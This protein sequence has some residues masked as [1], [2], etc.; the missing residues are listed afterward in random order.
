MLHRAEP[1]ETDRRTAEE[2]LRETPS[3]LVSAVVHLVGLLVLALW[4]V[5][6]LPREQRLDLSTAFRETVELEELETLVEEM[7]E[8]IELTPMPEFASTEPVVESEELD[9]AAFEDLAAAE[10]SVDLADI[11]LEH[12]PKSDLLASIG[13]LTG[14]ALSGRGTGQRRAMVARYGGNEASERAVAAALKWLSEHQAPDG[15]WSFQ[16]T[17]STGCRGQCR[18]PGSMV[19]ARNAATSMALLPFLGAGQTHKTGKYKGTVKAGLYY[20][21]NRMK[22]S[23]AGGSLFEPGGRMYAHG[24]GSIVLCEAYGMTHDKGL[25]APAQQAVNYICYAQDPVGGG[26]RYEPRQRGDTSVVGWQ[27]MAL[28]SGHMAYLR[29]PPITVK[30]ANTFLDTVQADRGACYGYTD[31]GRGPAT[32][33]IG[34]LSRMYLGWAKDNPSLERGVRWLASRGPAAGNMYYNYYATQ[35]VRHWG[36]EF[37]KKWN[38]VMRD[39]LVTSQATKGHEAGSWYMEAGDH[40]AKHGGRLYCTAMATMILEVYY[41]H[42]PIYRHQSIESNF[43]LD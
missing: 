38:V 43:P 19:Q 30:R 17:V 24:L 4:T 32:T 9:V 3:W 15:G 10:V 39:Q 34:L 20:L 16:H 14:N 6:E 18:N 25:Y 12:A 5:P 21:V 2:L 28:K 42:L 23:P 27:L 11:G 26:W 8:E 41:R 36:G 1:N 22:V 33:A 35:V 29:V 13:A 7:P 40:G 37:W 31:P